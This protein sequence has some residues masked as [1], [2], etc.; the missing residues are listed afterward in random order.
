[1]TVTQPAGGHIG[2]RGYRM[3][4]GKVA[5]DQ[6]ISV[7][8]VKVT[9][10]ARTAVDIARGCDMRSGL[11]VCDAAIRQ[12]IEAEIAGTELDLREAVHD[13]AMVRAAKERLFAVTKLM[14]RWPGSAR[15]KLAIFY[16]DPASE[17]ALES[18]SRGNVIEAELPLPQLNM[19]LWVEGRLFY[20]DFLWELY[21]LIGEADGRQKYVEPDALFR[22]KL[23]HDALART[24][25]ALERWV[26]NEAYP[27]PSTMLSRLRPHF[28]LTSLPV[29]GVSPQNRG[30]NS[31]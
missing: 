2:R 4:G 17:S 31:A 5:P 19:P 23:R 15:A 16:A 24:G 21:R 26:W 14:F 3:V 28:G 13:A 1:M 22:E 6:I 18:I 20:P 12:L 10:L 25:R 7:D 27:D 29:G 8:G 30:L 11:V 9:S